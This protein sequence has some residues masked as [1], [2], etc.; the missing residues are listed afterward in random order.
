MPTDDVTDALRRQAAFDHVRKLNETRDVITA[1]DLNRGFVYQG[2]RIA[3]INPRRGI[4]TP[5]QMKYLLSI[6][7]VFPKPGNRVWYDDQREVHRQLFEAEETVDYA[8]TG[9]DPDAADNRALRDAW[10]QRIPIMYFLGI[11]PGRYQVMMPAFIANWDG[12]GLKTQVAFGQPD[13]GLLG[14]PTSAAERRYAL[15]VVQQRLHQASFRQA[16]LSA[17]GGR[18]AVSALP[19]AMLLD[20]A[21]IVADADEKLGQPIIANG[22][23]LSKLHHAALDAHLIGIDPD[24]RVHVSEKL[25]IQRDGPTLEALKGLN[26]VKL[27][28][29][30]RAKDHPDRDRLAVRFERF[31]I[32]A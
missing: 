12:P 10:E 19:E 32:A 27:L 30:N 5:R 31:Q 13:V 23:A 17:Y 8:F 26:G 29:P 3:L 4:F 18:C 15:R 11:A 14:A 2:E 22:L 25:L 20:A 24:F 16:V 28:L 9:T 7:T 21:H 1:E 6:K